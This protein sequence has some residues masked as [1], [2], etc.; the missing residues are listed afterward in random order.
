MTVQLVPVNIQSPHHSLTF[1]DISEF[2]QDLRTEQKL[3]VS[4][5]VALTPELD[6]VPA[7]RDVAASSTGAG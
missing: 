5:T 1:D 4:L 7:E 6:L 2:L 3:A